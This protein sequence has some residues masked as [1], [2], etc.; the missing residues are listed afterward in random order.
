MVDRSAADMTNKR[1]S[2]FQVSEA[3]LQLLARHRDFAEKRLPALIES[4][5]E[6]FSDWPEIQATLRIPSVH[7]VRVRHW[8]LAASGKLDDAFLESANRLA[9]AFYEHGVPAYAVSICHSIVMRGVIE[10]L[11]LDAP[12]RGLFGRREAEEKAA[13]RRAL[14]KVV[15]LDLELLLETYATAEAES[16]RKIAHRIA[17]DLEGSIKSV[18]QNTASATS[19][20]QGNAQ[21]MTQIAETTSRQSEEVSGAAAQAS[22]NVQTVAA[23]AEQ[24]T[25][26]ISEIARNV[27]QSSQIASSA[28]VEAERTNATVS[29]LVEAAKRI[30]EVVSLIHNIASQTNLLALNATIEAARA[31]EAGKGFAV[32]A[33]EVKNLA[34]QTAKATEEISSQIAAMQQAARDSAQAIGSVGNTI[35]RINAI[36]TNVAAAVEEQAASTEEIARN[37]QEAATGTERVNRTIGDVTQGATETGAIAEEVLQAADLLRKDADTLSGEVDAFLTRIRAA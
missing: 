24:L 3:D 19:Q 14:S 8:V 28:V 23:A 34:N 15:W 7:A 12:A 21:R 27:S 11:Q 35:T 2:V 13:L 30:D 22:M 36:V 37:V 31:G 18:I 20:M 5:H 1:L 4:W 26:S 9:R 29:G 6:R 33:S 10:E 16:K 32:V 17:E 25:A